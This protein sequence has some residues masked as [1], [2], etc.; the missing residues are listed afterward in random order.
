MK[1]PKKEEA[2]QEEEEGGEGEGKGLFLFPF[3]FS[4]ICPLSSLSQ[5]NRNPSTVQRETRAGSAERA[6]LVVGFWL[7]G[8]G[9]CDMGLLNGSGGGAKGSSPSWFGFKS[10]VR[11][12]QV[13]SAHTNS[14]HP[15]LAKELSVPYLIAIGNF[16]SLLFCGVLD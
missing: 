1:H 15:K 3:I 12:K 4:V 13:D 10:L 8:F 5:G 6:K 16:F 14:I 9:F 2:K 7:L 11:R